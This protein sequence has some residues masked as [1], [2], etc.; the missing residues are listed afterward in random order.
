[1]IQNS[2][3]ICGIS[4]AYYYCYCIGVVYDPLRFYT[5]TSSTA[6][7]A[8]INLERVIIEYL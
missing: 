5:W 1:M 3:T 2:L 7:V 8:I 4:F 6:S